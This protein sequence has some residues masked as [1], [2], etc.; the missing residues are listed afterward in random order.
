MLKE[1]LFDLCEDFNISINGN[2]VILY[3]AT[4]EDNAVKIAESQMMYGKEDGLFF[5]NIPHGE[6]SGYGKSIIQVEI[7]FS[8]I[9][10][11]D[12]FS[13]ELHFRMPCVPNKYYKIKAKIYK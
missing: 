3:H 1:D 9:E 8:K 13:G 2:N 6:I 12:Q 10:L 11:D 4:S 7:P 5:S